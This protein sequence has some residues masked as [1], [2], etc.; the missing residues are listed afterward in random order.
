MMVL[1]DVRFA[2][3]GREFFKQT[4]VKSIEPCLY[5]VKSPHQ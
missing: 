3:L 2:S 5:Q 4:G 1:A